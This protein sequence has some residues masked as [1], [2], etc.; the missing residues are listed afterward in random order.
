[1]A[2]GSFRKEDVQSG[3]QGF[4][5]QAFDGSLGDYGIGQLRNIE[6]G[7]KYRWAVRFLEPLPPEPFERFFPASDIDFPEATLD[8]FTFVQGQT[9]LKVPQ[10]Q[11]VREM[12]LTFYDN[13]NSALV[14]WLKDWI[15]IDIFND[16]K[17]VSCLRDDHPIEGQRIVE[18]ERDSRVYPVRTLQFVK[19][20]SD[21]EPIDGTEQ[22]LDVYPEGTIN[23]NGS[24]ASEA[25]LYTINFVIVGERLDKA[26]GSNSEYLN[27]QSRGLTK[28]LGRFI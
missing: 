1:M 25:L 8:S 23:F 28:I 27:R 7:V 18:F 13:E 20:N 16:G 19:L 22:I 15:K 14:N 26:R 9:D 24:S 4:I 6:W 5:R 3:V 12:S 11:T 21:L 17:F 2:F 10:R